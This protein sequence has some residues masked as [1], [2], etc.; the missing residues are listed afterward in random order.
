MERVVYGKIVRLVEFPFKS[1]GGVDVQRTHMYMDGMGFDR[2][3]A[4]AHQKPNEQGVHS[5]ATQR[6]NFDGQTQFFAKIALI[7]PRYNDGGLE[8]T[9]QGEDP[10][11]VP[12]D[13]DTEKLL[14]VT[15]KTFNP[16]DGTRFSGSVFIASAQHPSLDKWVTEHVGAPLH[17]VKA[18][19]A[20]IRYTDNNFGDYP[21]ELR[22]Q[23]GFPLSP[24][25]RASVRA[26]NQVART[27]ADEPE[28]S[29]GEDSFR[30]NIIIDADSPDQLAAVPFSEHDLFKVQM[31]E[32][33]I[34]TPKPSGRCPITSVDQ[35][36]AH[37]RG[38]KTQS[39]LNKNRRWLNTVSNS[40]V[41]AFAENGVPMNVG[42]IAVG[43]EV[44]ALAS[45]Y[46]R[47]VFGGAEIKP[48]K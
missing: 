5:L 10:I 12:L 32:I 16:G 30:G 25:T 3:F 38:L 31:G 37:I 41:V 7:K 20:H 24:H 33:E 43:D 17:V 45:K 36:D 8:L 13:Y 6:D 11:S 27:M 28:F 22:Y 47:L 42:E 29:I 21:N 34:D 44:Y 15:Y 40:V 18:G 14:P 26:V 23:D 39:V 4:F 1:A 9:W 19:K 48:I 46:P 35:M 2:M